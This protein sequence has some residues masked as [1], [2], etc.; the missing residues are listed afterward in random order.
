MKKRAVLSEPRVSL[1]FEKSEGN[2]IF[3]TSSSVFLPP[4]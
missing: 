4:L 2:Y 1:D 3:T